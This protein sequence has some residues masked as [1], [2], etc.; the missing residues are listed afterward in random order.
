MRKLFGL[1]SLFLV[2][3]GVSGC[4]ANADG[5]VKE[6]IQTMNDL[7]DALENKAPEAKVSELKKK[8][9]DTDKKL[10]ALKLSGA[11]KKKLVERHQ[12][13]LMKASMRLAKAGMSKA[14]G[15]FGMRSGQGFPGLPDPTKMPAFPNAGKGA[16]GVPVPPG[17]PGA[18]K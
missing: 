15:D 12:E 6:E 14:L 18:G 9:E 3:C 17:F 8:L 2:V 10:Q 5:L 1:A 11:D 13:E 4:G 16:G 7:A